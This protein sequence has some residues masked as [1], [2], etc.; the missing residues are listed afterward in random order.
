MAGVGGFLYNALFKRTSTFALTIIG[1]TFFFERS[2]EILSDT[3][4]DNIN[5]GKLWKHI[6]DKYEQ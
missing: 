2:F 3:L 1:G 6:K 4:Y 5:Q